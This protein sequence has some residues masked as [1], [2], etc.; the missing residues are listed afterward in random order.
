MNPAALPAVIDSGVMFADRALKLQPNN[1]DAFEVKGKLEWLRFDKRVDTDP[2]TIDRLLPAAESDL[3]RAVDLNKDQAGA[4]VA[5]SSLYYAKTDIQAANTAALN[6]YR[7]DAY[8][9][10]ARQVLKRLWS[11]SHDLEQYPEALKWCNEGRRRFPTDPDFTSCRLWMYTTRLERPDID[12]VWSYR[13]RYVALLPAQQRSFGQRMG[14]IQAAGAL[15]RAGLADS[16]RRVLLRARATPAEDP[17]RELEGTEAVVR[18]ILGDHDEAIRLIA[19][20]LAVN[21]AHRKGFA[22]RTS[23]WWRDLQSNPKFKR[24]MAGAR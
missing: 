2:N 3:T 10:S 7:A 9:S 21:P 22:T 16:A 11:T 19:D 18:V 6:A 12:S 8:L 24:L 5:L 14:D 4:W 13:N 23:P 15:A 20:Y 1:P 17:T